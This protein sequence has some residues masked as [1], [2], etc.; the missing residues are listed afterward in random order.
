MTVRPQTK[1]CP[2]CKRYLKET[3]FPRREDGRRYGICGDCMTYNREHR[4]RRVWPWYMALAKTANQ[5]VSGIERAAK[6][7]TAD[8]IL[9]VYELQHARC[10]VTHVEFS[11]PEAA[12]YRT[13][14][15][16]HQI[17]EHC[18][19]PTRAPE[20]VRVDS[21]LPWE[22]G[23]LALVIVPLGD[24]CRAAGTLYDV[25][26]LCKDAA[27]GALS[28][29]DHIMIAKRLHEYALKRKG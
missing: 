15:G 10:A 27:L 28:A 1:R 19:H 26:Q 21:N 5:T 7:I 18:P 29:P 17:R 22:P 8:V 13:G 3:A 16:W 12:D 25:Q 6:A 2:Q 23:N 24:L 20:L 4:A 14:T 11:V 9:A